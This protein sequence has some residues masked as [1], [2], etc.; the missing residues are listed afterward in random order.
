M[1]M[2]PEEFGAWIRDNLSLNSAK[3]NSDYET[4]VNEARKE[5]KDPSITA[6]DVKKAGQAL[7]N[8]KLKAAGGE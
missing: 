6:D 8:Q 7:Y 3:I 1:K 2:A 4:I 5:L